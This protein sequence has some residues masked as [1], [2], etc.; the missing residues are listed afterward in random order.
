MKGFHIVSF[1]LL[2]LFFFAC[3]QNNPPIIGNPPAPGFDLSGSDEKAIAIADEV[4]AACGGRANWEKA[5]YFSWVFAGNRKHY[6]DKATGDI[7]IESKKDS[8][9]Y[10]MNINTMQGKVM[11]QGKEV[12]D[13]ATLASLL[14]RG[15]G[16]WI[17][18]SYWLVMPF[19]MKDSGVSLKYL[20]EGNTTDGRN[21]DIISMTFKG[22]GVTPENKYHVLVD[23]ESKMITEWS[24]FSEA[25]KDTANFTMPWS[26]YQPYGKLMLSDDR[27]RLQL[28]EISVDAPIPSG[29][30][31]KFEL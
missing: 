3:Q 4:M 7:R 28:S 22:V 31:T 30:F 8:T 16:I 27:G 24:Y 13:T 25:S 12:T 21:A 1:L 29:V 2:S 26:N 11:Q 5:R 20:G 18:D 19:K 14:K 6:W 9:I 17:N 23:K 15:K 10:L